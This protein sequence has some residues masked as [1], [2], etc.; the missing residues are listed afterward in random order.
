[1]EPLATKSRTPRVNVLLSSYNGASYIA[2]Q[3]ESVLAQV[4]VEV[5]LHI[6]DDG[7]S[8][9]TLR[10]V[11]CYKSMSCNIHVFFGG[12]IGYVKSFF[13]LLSDADNSAE[14]FAFCDQD[15]IWHPEKLRSAVELINKGNNQFPVMYFSRTEY[16]DSE[17]VHLGYSADLNPSRIGYGNALVQNVATGCTMVFNAHARDLIISKL[18]TYCLVH[19][20]WIYLV[21]SFFG[22][23]IYDSRPFIKYRQHSG[24][25][26]GAADTFWGIYKRRITRFISAG[27]EKRVSLQLAQFYELYGSALCTEQRSKLRL[28]I[29]SRTSWRARVNLLFG[30][31][32]M[33]NS[34]VDN[35][36]LKIMI[37][38]G[39]F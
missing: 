31:G 15:D 26:I 19:D 28:L 9:D 25:A 34:A 2:E 39:R 29:E 32:Y 27:A 8:D 38:I 1:M 7:S 35:V 30:G 11:E 16:V 22:E 21:V 24:N 36:L 3:I 20:W 13:R 37:L 10:I 4:G 18:P 17:L 6:R 23:V 5:S 12:N 14:Y 33:R